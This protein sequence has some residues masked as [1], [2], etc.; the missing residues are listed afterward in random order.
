MRTLRSRPLP[1]RS[2]RSISR[3]TGRWST[4]RRTCGRRRWK[5]AGAP[6]AR[7]GPMPATL[8]PSASPT[9]GR[10]RCYGTAAPGGPFTAP[11]SG[12]IGGRRMFARVCGRPAASRS[13]RPRPACCSIPTSPAPS[14]PGSCKKMPAS[15]R[16]PRAASSPSEPSTLICCGVSPAA[17]FTPPTQRMR[18]AP[19]CSTFMTAAGTTSCWRCSAYRR[20]C[21]RKFSIPRP[22]SALPIPNCSAPRFPFTALPATSRRR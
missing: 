6:C 16:L 5:P 22:P 10:P 18:R 2:L 20:P 17:E 15:R 14:S 4:S 11:S 21:C 13:L 3:L 7:P 1:S 19:C 12:R 8:S 9:S